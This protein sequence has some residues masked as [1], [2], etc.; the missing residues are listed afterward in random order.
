M[1]ANPHTFGLGH[2]HSFYCIG[3]LTSPLICQTLLARGWEWQNF[4][5]ISVALPVLN[6][7][8]MF[9]TFRPSLSEFLSDKE[10]GIQLGRVVRGDAVEEGGQGQGGQSSRHNVPRNSECDSGY[11]GVAL[12]MR[13]V[14]DHYQNSRC[15]GLWVLRL[16]VYG[17][18]RFVVC[19][20]DGVGADFGSE[21]VTS[22]YIVTYLLKLRVSRWCT[23]F[24]RC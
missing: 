6:I 12:M 11:F 14:H 23:E 5:Y 7:L 4:Y 1:V 8:G 19:G 21:G 22:G 10:G 13:S 15:L 18:V 2:M 20:V 3:A 24:I 16:H 17:K 9:V